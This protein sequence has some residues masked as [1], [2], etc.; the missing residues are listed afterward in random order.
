[1][2]VALEASQSYQVRLRVSARTTCLLHEPEY[3]SGKLVLSKVADDEAAIKEAMDIASRS[4]VVV[5]F[6]VRTGEYESEGFNL[7]TIELPAN[8]VSLI[9]AVASVALK[10]VLVL[11][12]GNPIDISA[13]VNDVDAN[14]VAHFPGQE[15]AISPVLMSS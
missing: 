10:T 8:Q 1:V 5:I 11:H 7:D 2:E 9:R 4:D 12:H 15:G 3:L 6:G 14:F 13:V